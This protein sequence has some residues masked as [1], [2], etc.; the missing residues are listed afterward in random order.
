MS[1]INK[2]H[3]NLLFRDAKIFEYV[4]TVRYNCN[5]FDYSF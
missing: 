5:T 3:K 1:L 4:V 2:F